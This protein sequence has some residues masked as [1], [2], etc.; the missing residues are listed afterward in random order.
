MRPHVVAGFSATSSPSRRA[1]LTTTGPAG[2]SA[3]ALP[4]RPPAAAAPLDHV[5]LRPPEVAHGLPAQVATLPLDAQHILHCRPLVGQRDLADLHGLLVFDAQVA[6]GVAV[7]EDAALLPDQQRVETALRLDAL[8][9][10]Q[11]LP[12]RL[13]RD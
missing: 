1:L 4:G 12:A 3:L 11:V 9:R 2:P 8:L 10:G 5:V 13:E 7:E 6:A